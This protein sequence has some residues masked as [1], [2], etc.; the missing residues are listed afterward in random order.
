MS[1]KAE[2]AM[3]QAWVTAL[4]YFDHAYDHINEKCP[5]ASADAKLNAAVELARVAAM[6]FHSA[7]ISG[8]VED[9][10]QYESLLYSED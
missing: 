4:E 6:D 7:I 1:M 10:A 8:S 9:T 2:T 3:R 5:N